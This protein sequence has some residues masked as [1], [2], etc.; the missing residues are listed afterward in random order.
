M[1]GNRQVV[2]GEA[3]AVASDHSS[4]SVAIYNQHFHGV[5]PSDI[6]DVERERVEALL[7]SLPLDS[8]CAPAPLPP[9]STARHIPAVN[10]AFVGREDELCSL[11][12]SLKADTATAVAQVAAATGQGGFGKSQLASEFAHRY[13]RYFAGGVF[14]LSFA[15]A[16][17]IPTEIAA[18]GG[19]HGLGCGMRIPNS[20]SFNRSSR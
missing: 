8:V 17:A 10:H 16:N 1:D 9:G 5:K 20:P 6:E 2:N 4:S 11:A 3:I 12:R 13:G 14:W 15:D 18:C 7:N 19:P